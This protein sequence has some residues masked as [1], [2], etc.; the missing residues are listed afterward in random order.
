MTPS[1]I[2]NKEEANTGDILST[3][4]DP[5]VTKPKLQGVYFFNTP[6]VGRVIMKPDR[7][8]SFNICQTMWLLDVDYN[9][10]CTK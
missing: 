5:S 8:I 10:I 3:G 7:N 4:C 6:A 1:L 2:R 9:E